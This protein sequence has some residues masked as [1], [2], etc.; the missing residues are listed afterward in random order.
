M[1]NSREGERMDKTEIFIS[2]SKHL[3]SQELIL[4]KSHSI[5]GTLRLL[6]FIAILI[7]VF[8]IIKKPSS[9]IILMGLF[10][11]TILFIIFLVH[12]R[13]LSSQLKKIRRLFLINDKYMKRI[14]GTWTEFEDIGE[15]FKDLQHPYSNDLDIFGSNSLFQL[16][17][18]TKTF[19]GRHKLITLLK[20]PELD[21]EAITKRQTAVKELSGKIEFCENLEDEGMSNIKI[22]N[23]TNALLTFIEDLNNTFKG[24][25]KTVITILPIVTIVFCILAML[26]KIP[27]LYDI[28]LILFILH[29]LI[30][31]LSL[32]KVYPVLNSME[33]FNNDFA[34][35]GNILKLIEN[36][37]F[38]DSYLCEL[39]DNL[40]VKDKA[41][42]ILRKLDTII[43]AINFRNN[44]LLY[45]VLNLLFF[46]DYRC[47]FYLETWKGNYGTMV[48]KYL[49]TAADFEVISSLATI[50]HLDSNLCYPTFSSTNTKINAKALGHPLILPSD[51]IYN[52]IDLENNIFIIT[53]SNM[54]GK[55]TFLRTI[56]INLVLAYTGAP[57]C[58]SSMECSLLKIFTSMRISDDL[59]KGLSTFYVEL[60]RIK[61]ILDFLPQKDPMLFLIDE[62]FRGTNSNDRIIGAKTVLKN[63]DKE[64]CSGLIST[65]DFELCDLEEVNK[66]R[67]R[68]YHFRE[69]YTDNKI[70]FDYKLRDGR[71]DTT[72]AKYL[73]KMV[74]ID[75]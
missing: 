75:I 10:I 35:Y 70:H 69:D 11:S 24:Y 25:V 47:L 3:K 31:V 71:S 51:R 19:L 65:H 34:A 43:S 36:E 41:S 62:I 1:P 6:S 33:S 14:A 54:S 52:D 63:L 23:D 5:F 61:T 17:N 72:N 12:D 38:K 18:T 26:F 40:F 21:T 30:N 64:W 68:N 7:S 29:A 55:T 27:V 13:N 20:S 44:F 28:L 49:D 66:D 39:R 2:R 73:M 60:T 45:I 56:G 9:I 57:V 15:D 58:A 16:I 32:I 74:G 42:N 37:D 22:S 67:I 53:G 8:L 4:K 46:W 59:S 50:S 48:R